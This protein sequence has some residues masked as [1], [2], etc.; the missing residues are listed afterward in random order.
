MKPLRKG[1]AMQCLR[2]RGLMVQD[3]FY[4]MLDDSG[5]LSFVGWRCICCGNVLDP[6]ILKNQRGRRALVLELLH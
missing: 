2:C 3:H 1:D 6:L 4:D 5:H